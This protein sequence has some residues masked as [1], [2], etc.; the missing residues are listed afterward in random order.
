MEELYVEGVATHDGPEREIRGRATDSRR[1]WRLAAPRDESRGNRTARVREQ[2]IR[3]GNPDLSRPG[4]VGRVPRGH[5]QELA[6]KVAAEPLTESP[7]AN[8]SVNR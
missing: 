6:P 5:S 2:A 8:G 4:A 3:S 1:S 7:A